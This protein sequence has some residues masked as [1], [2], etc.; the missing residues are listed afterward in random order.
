MSSSYCHHWKL[1]LPERHFSNNP[2]LAT[3]LNS[4]FQIRGRGRRRPIYE[5]PF[6]LKVYFLASYSLVERSEAAHFI[7]N[8]SKLQKRSVTPP[9][10]LW[11]AHHEFASTPLLTIFPLE[12]SLGFPLLF[13]RWE[14]TF[15]SAGCQTW[16]VFLLALTVTA[17]CWRVFRFP[18]PLVRWGGEQPERKL[19]Q[20]DSRTLFF[21]RP[22]LK[23]CL[24]Q[25]F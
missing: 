20:E 24:P 18:N 17:S 3:I 7:W 10:L 25:K 6:S 1:R 13:S 12:A 9:L 16:Q 23:S 22:G 5:F 4:Q 14:P 21:L 11:K 15:K 2:M 19:P 8:R